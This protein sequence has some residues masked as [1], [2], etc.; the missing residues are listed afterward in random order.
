MLDSIR[1]A[2]D[3]LVAKILLGILLLCFVLLW[4][5]PELNRVQS[6]DVFV[7]GS[8]YITKDQYLYVLNDEMMRV[9]VANGLN[10]WMTND[11]AKRYGLYQDV[12]SLNNQNVLLD[13]EA[14]RMKIGVS[15]DGIAAAIGTDHFF[16]HDNKFDL[17]LFKNFLAQIRARVSD[18][19]H[20]Y[21]QKQKRKQIT[22]SVIGGVEAPRQFTKALQMYRNETRKIDYLEL[23]PQQLPAIANPNAE[24]LQ[25]W[26]DQHKLQFRAPEYRTFVYMRM[27]ADDLIKA[28]QI[29]EDSLKEYYEQHIT[30]FTDPEKR[31]IDIL[32]FK[33][34][35]DADKAAQKLAAGTSFDELVKEQGQTIEA[36][37]QKDV[38]KS[39][40][41]TLM[42]SNLFDLKEGA[43]SG[44]I[45]DLQGPVIAR[46]VT[47][48]PSQP[49]PL[50]K[51]QN[52]IRQLLQR[53]EAAN[54]LRTNREAIE[55]E[56]NQ[57]TTLE[58]LSKQY[59]LQSQELTLD[60]SGKNTN[61]KPEN[62]LPQQQLLLQAV[63]QAIPGM[64]HD[65]I[66][67][68]EG[69]YVWYDVK[70]VTPARDRTLDEVRDQ[71]IASWKADEVQ[72]LLDKKMEDL[73]KELNNG[74]TLADLA[75]SLNTKVLTQSG[76]KRDTQSEPLGAEVVAAVFSGPVG[77][78][79]GTLGPTNQSRVL[80]KVV[81]AVE[82]TI[83]SRD[84]LDKTIVNS[85]D[86][87]FQE[88][89]MDGFLQAAAEAHPVKVNQTNFKQF[90]SGTEYE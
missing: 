3:T 41:P 67:L 74:K 63:F 56:R 81:D 35:E 62:D 52:E 69:G 11:E 51:V 55:N 82:P 79:G 33:K 18:A 89:I 21:A 34:R 6:D 44:V 57:G 45:N 60:A 85:V 49:I 32:R 31:V 20:Y 72:R 28:Q 9:S 36:I 86:R 23:T 30:R 39:A 43:I 61:G 88:T 42:A 68:K 38:V 17:S 16:Y 80:F 70:N 53:T 54:A 29:S 26:F 27:S 73:E 48:T 76:L 25:S 65:P 22:H 84:G 50:P 19:T 58:E 47:V 78:T 71:A 2:A 4:G 83:T 75:D 59:N 1:A 66:S 5:I 8:S 15:E 10:H 46:I 24:V 13:E 37:R 87:S 12:A 64:D 77:H 14:R 90:T 7:S 40:L